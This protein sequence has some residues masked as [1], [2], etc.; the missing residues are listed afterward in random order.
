[1]LEKGDYNV[2]AHNSFR[3]NTLEGLGGEVQR[4]MK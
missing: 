3:V 4:R 1:M 2:L